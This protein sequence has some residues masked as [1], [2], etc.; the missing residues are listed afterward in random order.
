PLAQSRQAVPTVCF[1][2]ALAPHKGPIDLLKS[3]VSIVKQ[4]EHTL[5]FAGDGPLE[6]DLRQQTQD[7]PHVKVLGRQSRVEVRELVRSSDVLVLPSRRS[8]GGS[9]AAG[10]VLLEAQAC[11]T[12]VITYDTGGTSE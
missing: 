9:E 5:V 3:S 7:Y 1:V 12:P 11:G 4:H 6:N 2:G 10:L 8:V